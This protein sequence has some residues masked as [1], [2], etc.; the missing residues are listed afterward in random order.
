[1]DNRVCVCCLNIITENIV[2]PKP[3]CYCHTQCVKLIKKPS[4]NYII[5]HDKLMNYIQ[6]DPKLD[7]KMFETIESRFGQPNLKN[8]SL[9][10]KIDK[11][12]DGNKTIIKTQVLSTQCLIN[13]LKIF[14][15]NPQN[16]K[17]NEFI[18]KIKITY[19]EQTLQQ[20]TGDI[21][22]HFNALSNFLDWS[23]KY[24]PSSV[25]IINLGLFHNKM[26]QYLQPFDF[27]AFCVEIAFEK[28]ISPTYDLV[29]K[30]DTYANK[31]DIKS[32]DH[33]IDFY[34]PLK[35][36]FLA[37]ILLSNTIADNKVK[38]GLD[39]NCL[40]L[41]ELPA[42][43]DLISRVRL[44][45]DGIEVFNMEPTKLI[46]EN[47]ANGI[48]YPGILIVFNANV[49]H[50]NPSHINTSLVKNFNIYIDW[51]DST[52][53]SDNIVANVL[54][55]NIRQIYENGQSRY[56]FFPNMDTFGPSILGLDKAD[57]NF[58]KTMME[59]K[60]LGGLG[61]LTYTD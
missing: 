27:W 37:P 5:N 11:Q 45:M 14:L 59:S 34:S 28:P 41:T 57:I 44:E 43:I 38:S 49:L 25:I 10:T 61:G 40:Y 32:I 7:F 58:Y 36:E 31:F 53:N 35:F 8:V 50:H 23:I 18:S 47:K 4:P 9:K 21:E 48:N 30:A 13:N 42:N 6:T 2:E 17:I 15:P 3:G 56:K 12:T 55:N 54:I 51:V 52:I 39:I 1:M 22:A 33:K 60:Q 26:L 16:Y 19:G 20:L 29:L 24:K 46:E